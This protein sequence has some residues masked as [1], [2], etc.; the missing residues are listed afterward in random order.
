VLRIRI[1]N[2]H[3]MQ[4]F[5]DEN[6]MLKSMVDKIQRAGANVVVCQKG[7]DDMTQHYLTNSAILG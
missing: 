7:V 4:R 6:K 3:Q 5:L 2:P 1:N